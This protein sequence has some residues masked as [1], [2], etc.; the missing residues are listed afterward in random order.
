MADKITVAEAINLANQNTAELTNEQLTQMN[1]AFAE[2]FFNRK[3]RTPEEQMASDVTI[4]EID[5]RLEVLAQNKNLY[6][7]K[8][9]D[10]I[11]AMAESVGMFSQKADVAKEVLAKA[12]AQKAAIEAAEQNI[13]IVNDDENQEEIT[14][15]NEQVIEIVED[16]S[17]NQE[18]ITPEDE[19][20]IEIVENSP[21]NQEELNKFD[22]ENGVDN[23]TR[24]QL[25]TNDKIIETLPYPLVCDSD[26]KLV[27]PEFAEEDKALKNLIITDENGNALPKME[28]D[29]ARFDIMAAAHLEAAIEARVQGNG[30]EED[31]QKLYNNLFKE[32]L[33]R[34]IVSAAF[35]SDVKKGMSKE[36][37]QEKF[38]QAISNP[39]KATIGAVRAVAGNSYAKSEKIVDRLKKK[40][41]DIP[42]VKKMDN[43]VKAFDQRMTE[44]YGKKWQT[45]KRLSKATLRSV[46]NVILYS[47]IG[48]LSGPAAP[49]AF[50][51]LAAKSA[52]DSAKALQAE[53]K[54]NNMSLWQYGKANKAKV[55]LAFT[56]TGLSLLGSA[57]GVGNSMG[58][59]GNN[60]QV[61]QTTLKW[62]AR[63]LA[64]A[65]NAV[66]ALWQTA[67]AGYK[68]FVKKDN[69]SAQIEW[70]KA[71]E[72]W[73]RAGE[74][75]IGI[76]VGSALTAGISEAKADTVDG[77]TG[78][79]VSPQMPS[80]NSEVSNNLAPDW[81]KI[82]TH[83]WQSEA[84]TKTEAETTTATMEDKDHDGISDTIDRDAGQGW[85][86]ANETQLDR[87]M[88]ADPAKVNALLND[89]EW[90]SSD[91][92]KAMMENGKFSDEQLKGIHELASKEFDENG[93]I[94]DADLK[95]YYEEQARSAATREAGIGEVGTIE[96]T[97]QENHSN[98]SQEANNEDNQQKDA[99]EGV[100]LAESRTEAQQRAY[101]AI[102]DI[103]SKG[104]NLND[105]EVK[106]SLEGM[107]ATYVEQLQTAVNNGDNITAANIVAA[108][109]NQGERQEI[110]EA[111]RAD[112]NDSRKLANAKED[113]LKAQA[114]LDAAQE[115]YAQDQNNEKLQKEVAELKQKLANEVLDLEQRQI[116]EMSS[117]LEEENKK[118]EKAYDN[119]EKSYQTTEKDHG[120]NEEEV[121]K[122]LAAMGI[123]INNLP[124]DM[125]TLP[126]EARNIISAHN[127]YTKEHQYEA[128][129]KNQIEANNQKLQDLQQQ[130]EQSKADEKAFNKGQGLSTE[131]EER[132]P[133][134]SDAAKS[135]LFASVKEM[136]TSKI[137]DLRGVS[138]NS[139]KTV[140]RTE[141]N[142][143]T[144][145]KQKEGRD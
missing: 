10:G 85:A 133:G 89:G 29:S 38:A 53:A 58:L 138:E 142:T 100:V 102:M 32:A 33:Q 76:A 47:G 24:E 145:L 55:A 62:S 64:V 120:M 60:A 54:K 143:Q 117:Q 71:K 37:L 43:Q 70:E 144:M 2:S 73:T 78:E 4:A 44:R 3:V 48:A 31:I 84:E 20:A 8:D 35:A 79:S 109:H 5:A 93:H 14:P 96:A 19:Q 132:L 66:P 95:A 130:E 92:L 103:I 82:M 137:N 135:E 113:V 25:E 12:Q 124:Q 118:Y 16:S 128:D 63:G 52:Y 68:K 22:R 98:I 122:G 46:G 34:N 91:E 106:A 97:A 121:A 61:V 28:Q 101:N 127:L 88:D 108:L 134:Q 18:E 74:A 40:F 141:I 110:A 125:S 30:K 21:E 13:E 90:H 115:A 104:E 49:A 26:G 99:T 123:D 87:L 51:G 105:P 80:Q 11:I 39:Q 81:E 116:K 6:D 136:M 50:L 36:Q 112:E 129:L 114:K 42:V 57:V 59:A 72:S 111:T 83:D 17:E 119:M 69:E 7:E 67:K 15:E 139:E 86:T 9:L 131:A 45:T 23:I 65:K 1:E 77:I 56:T 140:T 107:A 75:A 94:I 27:N 41:K 126:E